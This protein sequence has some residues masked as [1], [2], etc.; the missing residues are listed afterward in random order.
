MHDKLVLTPVDLAMQETAL[1]FLA[2]TYWETSR[3]PALLN[4]HPDDQQVAAESAEM[5]KRA[6]VLLKDLEEKR[7]RWEALVKAAEADGHKADAVN[8][9]G[10]RCSFED[11]YGLKH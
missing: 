5:A 10:C 7:A 2:D 6:E 8:C 11:I 3:D 9:F 1:R 4:G